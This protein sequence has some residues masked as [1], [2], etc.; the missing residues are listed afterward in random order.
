MAVAGSVGAVGLASPPASASTLIGANVAGTGGYGTATFR[1]CGNSGCVLANSEYWVWAA[2]AWQQWQPPKNTCVPNATCYPND[3]TS[4]VQDAWSWAD[5]QDGGGHTPSGGWPDAALL[6][7]ASSG[8]V[9]DDGSTQI[10]AGS[11]SGGSLPSGWGNNCVYTTGFGGGF[12]YQATNPP[13]NCISTPLNDNGHAYTDPIV[14][15]DFFF[16][17][18]YGDEPWANDTADLNIMNGQP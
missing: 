16:S 13:T 7:V 6:T 8:V 9:H 2:V 17:S 3:W 15:D 5:A 11:Y 12:V 4:L 18:N 14:N 10:F 1:Y